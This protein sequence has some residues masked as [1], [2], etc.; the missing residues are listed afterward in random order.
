MLPACPQKTHKSKSITTVLPEPPWHSPLGFAFLIGGVVLINERA[1]LLEDLAHHIL[2]FVQP[3][4][5]HARHPIHNDHTLH[6][7][8]LL[9][10]LP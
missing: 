4:R 9:G 6:A 5:S 1:V 7:V 10:L 2:Q 8:C 3:L